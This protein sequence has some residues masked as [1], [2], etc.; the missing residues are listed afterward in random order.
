MTIS[1]C[2]ND[3]LITGS[4][5]VGGFIGRFFDNTEVEVIIYNCVNNGIITGSDSLGGFVGAIKKRPIWPWHF[6]TA[7]TMR[8][9][10]E[11]TLLGGLLAA[12]KCIQIQSPLHLASSTVPT[13]AMCWLKTEW[14]VEC[15]VST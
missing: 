8:K 15:S 2:T 4:M 7:P 1:N 5:K 14:L 9:S 10:V 11:Q 12:L 3:G 13:K 6:P